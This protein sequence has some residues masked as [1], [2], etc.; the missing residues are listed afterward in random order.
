MTQ[1]IFLSYASQDADVARRICDALRASGL[2][3][4]FDQSELRG[5][6]AW[7]ASIRKQIKECALFV[8]IIS[9]NTDARSE[10]YFRLEWKLAVDRSHLMADDQ[11]FFVPVLLSDLAEADARVPDKFRERQW[12]PLGDD[13]AIE[14]FAVRVRGLVDDLSSRAKPASTVSRDRQRAQEQTGNTGTTEPMLRRRWRRVN[15][16]AILIAVVATGAVGWWLTDK[17]RQAVFI[18]GALPKIEELARTTRYTAAFGLAREVEAGGGA[19]ALTPALREGYS[20]EVSVQSQ[21]VGAEIAVKPFAAEG[22]W[23]TLGRTPLDKVRVPRGPMQWRATLAGHRAASI[24]KFATTGQQFNFQLPANSAPDADMVSVSGGQSDPWALIGLVRVPAIKLSPFL[25]DRTEVSNRE[26]ARFVQVGGYREPKF[27]KQ[28]F[29][30]DDK[31]ITF[32]AAM[33][34]FRDATGRPGPATWKLGSYPD[35]EEDYPVRGISWHEAAAYASFA[36]KQLPSIH[37]WYW[38]ADAGDMQHFP[39]VVLPLSNFDSRQRGLSQVGVSKVIG[40]FGTV[41]MAGNVREWVANRTDAGKYVAVGGSS[42]EPGYSYLYPVVRSGFDRSPD[43]GVRCMKELAENASNDAALAV[44]KAA[45]PFDI[46]K[47]RPASDAEYAVATRF[48]ERRPAALE[49]KIESTDQSSPHWIRYRVSFAA[50]YGDER[51]SV[52]LYLPRNAKPPYQTLIQMPGLGNFYQRTWKTDGDYFGWS[53]AEMLIRGGRAM[54]IPIWKG[55]YERFDGFQ[56]G[57]ASN[58]EYRGRLVQ[59]VSEL[60]QMVDYLQSRP[61]I[62]GQRIGYHGISF[63]ATWAPLFLALEPRLTTGVLLLGGIVPAARTPDISPVSYAPRVKVPVLMLNG[64]HDPI[65][66]YE[67]SQ[68][69]LFKLLGTPPDQKLHRAFAGGHSWF[70]WYDDMVREHYDWL[71]KV[72]GPVTPVATK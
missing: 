72:F 55:T 44:L 26:F 53:V 65:F 70:D 52:L 9:A 33:Q 71:D 58:S 13:P 14:A 49:A 5:G 34:R 36:G 22:E 28:P 39:G 61:D 8:P 42:M 4:W 27:W 38:A 56:P 45:P 66:P 11:A 21:P 30:D 43:T 37:Q 10:G 32:D 7:D 64:R 2:E 6:D 24:V 35:G 51:M 60:Q 69:P 62:D 3:V 20:R 1:A 15:V 47:V 31:P 29:L 57:S 18:A 50:G 67:T 23:I 40:A 17:N 68:V 19:D 25:M 54:V 63:G 16:A 41:N 46:T 59:W 12:T 48:F